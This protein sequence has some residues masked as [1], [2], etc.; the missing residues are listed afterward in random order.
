MLET[1]NPTI[2]KHNI[3]DHI[4]YDNKKINCM[5]KCKINLTLNFFRILFYQII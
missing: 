1:L 4:I 2:K 3:R 5:L